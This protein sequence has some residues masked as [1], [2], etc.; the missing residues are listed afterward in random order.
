MVSK[1]SLCNGLHAV[2]QAP[3]VFYVLGSV[4]RLSFLTQLRIAWLIWT[5]EPGPAPHLSKLPHLVIVL[6]SVPETRKQSRECV[7]IT[8]ACRLAS[9]IITG[10]PEHE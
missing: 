6:A 7:T 10:P 2:T 3:N 5:G 4:G 9:D 8:R 1:Y